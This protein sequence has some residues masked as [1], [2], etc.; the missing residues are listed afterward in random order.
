M[1]GGISKKQQ[2]VIGWMPAFSGTRGL[3]ELFFCEIYGIVSMSYTV[4]RISLLNRIKRK[5]HFFK[6]LVLEIFV[7]VHCCHENDVWADREQGEW[8]ILG[9]SQNQHVYGQYEGPPLLHQDGVFQILY[10]QHWLYHL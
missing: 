10:Q 2:S 8:C 1:D 3:P 5:D 9:G 6:N 4:T 7:E